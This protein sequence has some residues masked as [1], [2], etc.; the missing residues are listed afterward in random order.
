MPERI[1]D[2]S[3]AEEIAAQAG[4]DATPELMLND[5]LTPVI[6][7]PQRPPLAASG[8][9]PGTIGT[10]SAAVAL[11]TSHVG[12]FISGANNGIGK[13]NWVTIDNHT[14]GTLSYRLI[15]LDSP[16]AGFTAVAARPAY[17]NAGN[18]TTGRVFRLTKNDAV[19]ISGTEMANFVLLNGEHREILGP[20]ILNNGALVI[21]CT[22]VNKE[23]VAA[24]GY[25]SWEA[26]RDQAPG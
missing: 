14:G 19:G 1:R 21:A 8:Y 23:V 26:I 24:F 10:T 3:V 11:N 17:I 5:F 15:R 13:V 25:E 7:G 16:F 2:S 18:P 9:F 12:I 22:T 4:T 20:W 6:F